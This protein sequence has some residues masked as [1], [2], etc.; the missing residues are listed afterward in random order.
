MRAASFIHSFIRRL[1]SKK[2]RPAL[3]CVSGP[4]RGRTAQGRASKSRWIDKLIKFEKMIASGEEERVVKVLV[5]GPPCVGKTSVIRRFAHDLFNGHHKTTVGIDFALKQIRWQGDI[6][7]GLQVRD[8]GKERWFLVLDHDV[9]TNK[10]G[11]ANL[12]AN[13]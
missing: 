11:W 12:L 4:A 13:W 6:K 10:R 9:L 1:S 2:R 3:V 5:L 8:G 7:I